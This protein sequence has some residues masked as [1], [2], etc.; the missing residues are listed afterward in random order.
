MHKQQEREQQ[1]HG[2]TTKP[3]LCDPTD[4]MRNHQQQKENGNP[5]NKLCS[6]ARFP[7]LSL[8]AR[9]MLVSFPEWTQTTICVVRR[10]FLEC[11]NLAGR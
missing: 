8:V 6:N 4:Q 10:D 11:H 1:Q 3:A 5:N 2:T 9:G 7:F